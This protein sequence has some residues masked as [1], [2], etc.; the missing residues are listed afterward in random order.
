MTARVLVVEDDPP[1]ASVLER[2]LELAGYEVE[3]VLDGPAG[4]SRWAD[5]G[6]HVVVLD[7]MLPGKDGFTVMRELRQAG[8]RE[9]ARDRPERDDQLVVHQLAPLA[10]GGRHEHAL[11][12]RIRAGDVREQQ[13]GAVEVLAQRHHDVPRLERAGGG[14]GQQRRVEHEVDVGDD[15]HVRGVRRQGALQLA[16]GVQAAETAA[17]DHDVPGHAPRVLA[18]RPARRLVAGGRRATRARLAGRSARRSRCRR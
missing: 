16:R 1:I 8:D 2:G 17:K 10:L 6:W 12:R 13:V 5:G 7:V 11:A 14:P 3:V 15:R 4:L 9:A 18:A